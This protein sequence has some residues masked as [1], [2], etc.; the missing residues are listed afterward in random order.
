MPVLCRLLPFGFA[1]HVCEGLKFGRCR[2]R[3]SANLIKVRQ[4]LDIS[5]LFSIN[6][7][8]HVQTA[9]APKKPGADSE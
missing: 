1:A 3:D 9:R 4:G 5:G 8:F 2:L 7:L 6:W